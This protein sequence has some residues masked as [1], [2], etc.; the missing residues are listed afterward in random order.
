MDWISRVLIKIL[1]RDQAKF[2]FSPISTKTCRRA[3]ANV[4]AALV[5]LCTRWVWT[6]NWCL[7]L[8]RSSACIMTD[9]C[10]CISHDWGWC[11]SPGFI[12][13]NAQSG[14]L[15]RARP[16]WPRSVHQDRGE[17]CQARYCC[18]L[19]NIYK[20]GARYQTHHWQFPGLVCI[21]LNKLHTSLLVL[22]SNL[23]YVTQKNN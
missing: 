9:Q 14:I 19:L 3:T 22:V 15:P 21:L 18:F 12:S 11:I 10:W 8:Y 6:V 7:H 5:E 16:I 2:I 4:S 1:A 13:D 17:E 23:S 20:R